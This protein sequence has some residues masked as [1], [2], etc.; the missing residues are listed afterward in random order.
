MQRKL[1][2]DRRTGLIV[3]MNA[4]FGDDPARGER[5]KTVDSAVLEGMRSPTIGLNTGER[6]VL[7][8]SDSIVSRKLLSPIESGFVKRRARSRTLLVSLS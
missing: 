5:F 3:L 2:K 4:A 6:T 7:L 1:M 8:D